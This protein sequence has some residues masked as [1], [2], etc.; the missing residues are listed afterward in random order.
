MFVN[1]FNAWHLKLVNTLHYIIL[2][3]VATR[4]K[5]SNSAKYAEFSDLILIDEQITN[6]IWF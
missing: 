4:P 3:N 5:P 1:V 2:Q 6:G